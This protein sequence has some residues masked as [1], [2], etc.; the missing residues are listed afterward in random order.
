[1][2]FGKRIPPDNFKVNSSSLCKFYKNNPNAIKFITDFFVTDKGIRPRSYYKWKYNNKFYPM[3][4]PSQFSQMININPK[5]YKSELRLGKTQHFFV[6]I[7]DEG[8]TKLTTSAKIDKCVIGFTPVIEIDSIDIGDTQERYDCFGSKSKLVIKH[9]NLVNQVVKDELAEIDEWNK[10]KML[11]SGNGI[12]YILETFYSS[13][14][15]VDEYSSKLVEMMNDINVIAAKKKIKTL[16][17]FTDTLPW[18]DFFKIPFTLHYKYD[19]LSIPLNKD[20]KISKQYL[21][22]YSNIE[23]LTKNETETNYVI[24]NSGWY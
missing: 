20:E 7:F 1:M 21:E 10:T 2:A 12:Y 5:N 3:G 22:K 19:R 8:V 14:K 23:Y 6:Y 4:Y 24:K 15:K 9:F 18:N 16:V 11:F 13:R 17:D